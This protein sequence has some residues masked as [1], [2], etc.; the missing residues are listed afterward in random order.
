MYSNIDSTH[1][2]GKL[3][4]MT[5]YRKMTTD[6]MTMPESI[7]INFGNQIRLL[8]TSAKFCYF[9]PIL[10]NILE[11]LILVEIGLRQQNILSIYP[12]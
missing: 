4:K 2:I 12:N 5:K 7:N 6:R 9:R 8:Q 11:S 1:G 10:I 3:T